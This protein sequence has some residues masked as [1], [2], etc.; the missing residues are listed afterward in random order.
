MLPESPDFKH[1]AL[2][3]VGPDMPG[4][5]NVGAKFVAEH[6]GNIDKNIADKFGEHAAV[7]MSI[8]ASPAD[9]KRMEQDKGQLKKASGC[10]V[11]FQAMKEP[12]IPPSFQQELYGFDIV[13]DDA[14][15]LIAALTSLV[16]DF[17]MML[18]GHTGERKLMP[19]PRRQVQAGQKFIVVL[20][21]EFD[22]AAFNHALTLLVKK[23]N[24]IMASPLRPVPGLLWWW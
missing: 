10:A 21:H 7:F 3:L 17:G 16:A 19:G 9:I 18:V 8:T 14:V 11:V 6:G 23:Y 15:G 20:P 22:H 5:L 24:G 4:L 1:A 2:W 13:T 12:T